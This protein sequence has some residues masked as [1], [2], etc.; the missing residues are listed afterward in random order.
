L[1]S[2]VVFIPDI[3]TLGLRRE[4]V[5]LV[6]RHRLPAMYSDPSFVKIGGL[7]FYG[8]DRSDIFRRSAGYVDR[9]LYYVAKRREICRFSSQ[10][11]TS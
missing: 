1:A 5:D 8:A 2:R 10:Q 3:T 9:I 4:V 11:N 7:V 6:A